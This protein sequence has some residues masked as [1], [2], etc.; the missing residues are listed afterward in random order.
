MLE[1]VETAEELTAEVQRVSRTSLPG[2]VS[3]AFTWKPVCDT[4]C[5]APVLL[6]SLGLR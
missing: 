6:F 4:I 5:A 2:V 3:L 1:T